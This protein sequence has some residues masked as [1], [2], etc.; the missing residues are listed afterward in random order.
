V[1]YV[2]R[3]TFTV[4]DDSDEHLQ[5][6]QAIEE[7]FQSWLEGLRATV[8]EVTVTPNPDRKAQP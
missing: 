6:R 4:H 8:H 3:V 5:S 2:V 1:T 7:E